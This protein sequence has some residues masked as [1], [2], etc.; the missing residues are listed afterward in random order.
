MEGESAKA[1]NW[2]RE[3]IFTKK[4][5]PTA[6]ELADKLQIDLTAAK[7]RMARFKE[8]YFI[9][10]NNKNRRLNDNLVTES[11]TAEI[12]LEFRNVANNSEKCP[13]GKIKISEF[14]KHILD[15]KKPILSNEDQIKQLITKSIE[16][17][18]LEKVPNFEGFIRIGK[19][20]ENH[21]EYMI[22]VSGN[23]DN[24]S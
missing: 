3:F 11:E 6:Q 10:G 18:Y 21:R 14:L 15:K 19:N 20:L 13:D 17:A 24:Y 16:S 4:R 5:M 2:I 23:E 7:G 8:N 1:L 9:V 22:L 12:L